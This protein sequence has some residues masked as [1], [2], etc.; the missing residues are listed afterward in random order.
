M[1]RGNEFMEVQWESFITTTIFGVYEAVAMDLE[2]NFTIPSE[3]PP[4]QRCFQQAMASDASPVLNGLSRHSTDDGT[5]SVGEN[6][7]HHPSYR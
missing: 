6:H 3:C 4:L 1:G 7:T 5:G 2:E